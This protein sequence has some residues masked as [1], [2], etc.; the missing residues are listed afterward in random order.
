MTTTLKIKLTHS[1]VPTLVAKRKKVFSW[2][3]ASLQPEDP[4]FARSTASHT[5]VNDD[6]LSRKDRQERCHKERFDAV[7]K[8]IVPPKKSSPKKK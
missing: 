6:V 3:D 4:F 2:D 1:A 5:S 8:S 7:F